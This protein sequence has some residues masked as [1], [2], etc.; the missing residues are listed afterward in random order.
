MKVEI[1]IRED[2]TGNYENIVDER[3]FIE[4]PCRLNKDDLIFPW[5]NEKYIGVNK[6]DF[7]VV[8][9]LFT[10]NDEINEIYQIVAC[11]IR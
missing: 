10:I 4:S 2:K 9:C 11:E 1:L 5:V 7:Y 3:F 6:G 8:E